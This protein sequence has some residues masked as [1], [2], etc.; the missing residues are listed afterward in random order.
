MKTQVI[1]FEC[2]IKNK[3]GSL[4][5]SSTNRNVLNKLDTNN[6]T[7]YGLTQALQ[8]LKKGEVRTIE[9]NADEAYGLYDPKKIIFY[10]KDKLPKIVKIGQFVT[11]VDRTQKH[12]LYRVMNIQK[13]M[14]TLDGNHP[15]A[16]QDLVF[17]ISTLEV[18]DASD[19]EI[20]ASKN[21]LSE[22]VLH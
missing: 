10:S 19:M 21:L 18:R 13:E 3:D 14:I 8:N 11:V 7:L 20:D 15:L 16:G 4:I 22:Q 17:E 12:R 2:T 1:S 9:L 6:K 5:M